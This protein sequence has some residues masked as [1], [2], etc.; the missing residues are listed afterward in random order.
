MTVTVVDASVALKW[1]VA[2]Q[3][4]AQARSLFNENNR[5][6]A[7]E[8]VI[9]EVCNGAWRLARLGVLGRTECERIAIE[10]GRLFDR[11]AELGPLAPR[12]MAIAQSV[13]HPVYDCFYVALAERE[14][15]RLVTADGRLVRR[16]E[17]TQWSGLVHDLSALPIS[18]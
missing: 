8:L 17:G 12:A 13:D 5:L 3:G 16:F 6:A 1:F 4:S 11:I 9:A 10:I 15:G 7:P 18:P 2:E 14:A